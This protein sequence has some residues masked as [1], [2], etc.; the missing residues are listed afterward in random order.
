M[1]FSF[2]K[3]QR[4]QN[5]NDF[6]TVF[7]SPDFK[8]FNKNLLILASENSQ[9]KKSRLGLVVAKKHIKLAVK[10]NKLKRIFRESFRCNQFHLLN[11]DIILI[12]RND[13][14]E[15]SNLTLNDDLNKMWKK[16]LYFQSKKVKFKK[17]MVK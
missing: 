1:H 5:S 13:I 8:I 16:L 6:K 12:V 4:L 9:Q 15:I 11:L 2:K 10:R 7:D 14:S 3:V 17:N